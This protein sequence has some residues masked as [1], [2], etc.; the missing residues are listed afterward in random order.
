MKNNLVGTVDKIRVLKMYP[1]I[2]V[3]FTLI[4]GD[5]HV[6]CIISDHNLANTLLLLEEGVSQVATFG[7]YNNRKQ[8]VIEKMMLRNPSTFQQTYARCS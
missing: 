1:E 4:N 7:H 2:L 8:F 5:D 6:N 3:R